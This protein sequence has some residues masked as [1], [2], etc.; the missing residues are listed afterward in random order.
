MFHLH[1]GGHPFARNP[2]DLSALLS[3]CSV[4][5]WDL[6]L[7]KLLFWQRVCLSQGFSIAGL[8][9]DGG[10][11]EGEVG[12]GGGGGGGRVLSLTWLPSK[13]AGCHWQLIVFNRAR[14]VPACMFPNGAAFAL[15][16]LSF[17]FFPSLY[18]SISKC[19]AA[20]SKQ[21]RPLAEVRAA[22]CNLKQEA[23]GGY[24]HGMIRKCGAE[25]LASSVLFSVWF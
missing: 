7:V 4:T 23:V 10:R 16:F 18:L 3:C 1:K 2:W 25:I 19:P 9:G 14:K 24:R 21:S 12:G 5:I 8:G 20:G 13:L 6:K 11:K 17:F 22:L 15:F